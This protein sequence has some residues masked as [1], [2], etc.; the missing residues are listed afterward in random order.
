MLRKVIGQFNRWSL[1]YFLTI[2]W[3]RKTR[4]G[5][6][7]IFAGESSKSHTNRIFIRLSLCH[8]RYAISV[9]SSVAY[10]RRVRDMNHKIVK[11]NQEIDRCEWEHI[12]FCQE[13][14]I[15]IPCYRFIKV[16]RELL[17]CCVDL[18]WSWVITDRTLCVPLLLLYYFVAF[19]TEL[20]GS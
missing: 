2:C 14:F 6:L 1:K 12:H 4:K 5:I 9:V 10:G 15:K 20:Q 7:S 13:I 11:E 3:M 8:H 16:S 17:H 19:L 18:S